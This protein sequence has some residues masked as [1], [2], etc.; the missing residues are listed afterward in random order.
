MMVH[1][2]PIVHW[3]LTKARR[4]FDKKPLLQLSTLFE[5][6]LC[7]H[8]V[9][10]VEPYIYC[11]SL[12]SLSMIMVV[13]KLGDSS[14]LNNFLTVSVCLVSTVWQY[15]TGAVVTRNIQ[16]AANMCPITVSFKLWILLWSLTEIEFQFGAIC[17]KSW[18]IQWKHVWLILL[19]SGYFE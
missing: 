7:L 6:F 10:L 14:P 8:M 2:G 17:R 9:S 4:I 15:C 13:I 11:T 1:D 16:P 18:D 5:Q 3:G 19:K 12:K